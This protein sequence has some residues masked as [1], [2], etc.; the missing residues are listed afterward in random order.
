[1]FYSFEFC[2]LLFFFFKKQIPIVFEVELGSQRHE[3][4]HHLPQ[5]DGRETLVQGVEHDG[6]GGRL[7]EVL[8][9]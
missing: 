5:E 9:R 3:F 1:M 7:A 2:V 6:V 8:Q 4:E